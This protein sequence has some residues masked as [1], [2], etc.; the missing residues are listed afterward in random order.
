MNSCLSFKCIESQWN[1]SEITLYVHLIEFQSLFYITSFCLLFYC[2]FVIIFVKESISRHIRKNAN[3]F[4]VFFNKRHL[5]KEESLSS[6]KCSQLTKY[7]WVF[8]YVYL[9]RKIV[10]HS[11]LV[12][13]SFFYLSLYCNNIVDFKENGFVELEHIYSIFGTTNRI[14][15][16]SIVNWIDLNCKLKIRIVIM[17]SNVSVAML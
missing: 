1:S 14:R 6:L 11:Q 10:L 17:S 5:K 16:I 9:Q 2:V 13:I 8:R 15:I 7:P 12:F 4:S 3:L